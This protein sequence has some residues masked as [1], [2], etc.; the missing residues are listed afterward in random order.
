MR[1]DGIELTPHQEKLVLD[2]KTVEEAKTLVVGMRAMGASPAKPPA[3]PG[4]SATGLTASQQREYEKIHR[5]N[6]ER[7]EMYRDE[8]GKKASNG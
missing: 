4:R 8:I 3:R 7:A 6:P 2:S 5:T 1:A